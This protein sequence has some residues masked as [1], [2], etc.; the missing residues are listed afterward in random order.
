MM[1]SWVLLK[2]GSRKK[3]FLAMVSLS[4]MSVGMLELWHPGTMASI[5]SGAVAGIDQIGS[6]IRC[7]ADSLAELF[8]SI[9]S[10]SS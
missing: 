7:I 5:F 4:A 1:Q 2:G 9:G 8:R 6:W 3:W 10:W